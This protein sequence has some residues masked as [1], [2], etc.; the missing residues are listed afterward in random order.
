MSVRLALRAV[1]VSIAVAALIDPMF[2]RRLPAPLAIEFR[3]PAASH[4][5]AARAEALHRALLDALGDDVIVGGAADP[6]AVVAIGDAGPPGVTDRPLFFIPV[7]A[8]RVSIQRLDVPPWVAAGQAIRLT[9]SIAASGMNGRRTIIAV[10]MRGASV[11]SRTHQWTSDDGA[12]EAAL[13]FAPPATGAHRVR[14]V[15]QTDGEAERVV[16]DTMVT[17]REQPLRVL[18]Y[19]A[20][21]TWPV[22]FARRALEADGMFAVA[23]TTRSSRPAATTAGGAPPA[24][25]AID[26]D[27]YDAVLVGALDEL[28]AADLDAL[29]R[30]VSRRGGTLVLAPDRRIPAAVTRYFRLPAAEEVLLERAV[31]VAAGAASLRAS[32]LLL[33]PGAEGDPIAS[34]PHSGGT[35][36]AALALRHGDGQVVVSGLLDGWRYRGDA[37]GGFD[38]FWRALLADAALAAVPP[39]DL[40]V[41]PAAARPGER[42]RITVQVRRSELE[43]GGGLGVDGIAAVLTGPGGAEQRIR[44]WPGTRAGLFEAEIEAPDAGGYTVR[45]SGAQ[46][47][48]EIPLLVSGDVVQVRTDAGRAW[49]LAAAVTGGAVV[50][51]PEALR[52]ALTSV[53]TGT[54]ERAVRPMRSPWWIVP[55]AGLLCAEWTLRRR[56]GLI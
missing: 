18:V 24:L 34:A 36:P 52:G 53:S 46:S 16:A 11:A 37:A 9:A 32:E 43:T 20:R 42:L 41:T 10:H 8:P 48:V 5:D 38:A 13:T 49:R 50:T 31:T 25:A 40:R 12:F 23:A 6:Q 15:A 19:E 44:L 45:A 54:V 26:V 28:A 30:F 55:F 33:F 22:A 4:P 17:V 1:A 7:D 35:R 39:L 29:G 56:A 21:P 51:R 2:A 3:L 14:V 47:S 27:R